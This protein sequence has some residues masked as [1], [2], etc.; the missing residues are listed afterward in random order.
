MATHDLFRAREDATRVGILRDGK[1][2]AEY[3]TNDL[4]HADLEKLYLKHLSA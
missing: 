4:K 2:V 3:A 1:L